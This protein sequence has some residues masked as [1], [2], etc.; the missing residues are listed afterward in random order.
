VPSHIKISRVAVVPQVDCRGRIILNLSAGVTLAETD[1][2]RRSR[3]RKRPDT[4]LATWPPVNKTTDPA[5]DQDS[6]QA[7]GTVLPEL[8]YF[9][10]DTPHDWVIRWQKM[11]SRMVSGA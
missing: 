6:V 3:K 11:I 9:M 7:L 2:P 1:G 5:A 8:L 10:Y 4:S